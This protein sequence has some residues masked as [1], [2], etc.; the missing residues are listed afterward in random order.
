MEARP[1]ITV[2]IPT[3]PD[4]REQ[5]AR[6]VRAV[7]ENSNYPHRI[8]VYENTDGGWVP[9]VHNAIAD[10]DGYVALLGSDTIPQKDWLKNLAEAFFANFP[11]GDGVAEPFNEFN[12]GGELCQHPLAHSNTIKKYLFKGYTHWYSDN[13]FTDQVVYNGLYLYVPNAVVEHHHFLNHKAPMDETYRIIFNKE[14]NEKDRRL[15]EERRSERLWGIFID[16]F[17][18]EI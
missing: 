5:T 11:K 6:C 17:S 10:I 15:Y 7:V 2:V 9:A 16:N 12:H 8:L 3:T 14:T 4:R 18:E 1:I 13:D